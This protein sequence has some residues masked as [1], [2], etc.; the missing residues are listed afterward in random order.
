[1]L[2]G[3]LERTLRQGV[4]QTRAYMDRC[5]AQEGH[6]ILFHPDKP[7]R[8]KLFKRREAADGTAVV[9]WGM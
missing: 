7:W 1:M 6:L 4:A 3:N 2:R 5:G 9:L 8:D